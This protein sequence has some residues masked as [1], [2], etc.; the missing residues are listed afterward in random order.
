LH[1]DVLKVDRDVVHVAMVFQLYVL[2]I[3]SVLDICCKGFI[4]MF[5]EYRYTRVPNGWRNT[6]PCTS[7]KA[8]S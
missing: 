5:V 8:P 1:L 2:N 6:T 7:A 3:S 4:L